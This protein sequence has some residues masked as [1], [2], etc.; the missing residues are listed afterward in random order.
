MKDCKICAMTTTM[1][2]KTRLSLEETLISREDAITV[3]VLVTRLQ[4]GEKE[5]MGIIKILKV[6][7]EIDKAIMMGILEIE[8]ITATMAIGEVIQPISLGTVDIVAEK[9]TKGLI[10]LLE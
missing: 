4:H 1:E 7:L 3:E 5:E 9:V 2:V 10:V 6:R 8:I